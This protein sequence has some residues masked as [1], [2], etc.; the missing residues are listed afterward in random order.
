MKQPWWVLASS[1]FQYWESNSEQACGSIYHHADYDILDSPP[2][3][4]RFPARKSH[5]VIRLRTSISSRI[6]S[7]P[8]SDKLSISCMIAETGQYFPPGPRMQGGFLSSIS[9][10]SAANS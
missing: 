10:N 7:R 6:I 5:E 4:A 3:S 1:Q 9:R 8:I 2:S